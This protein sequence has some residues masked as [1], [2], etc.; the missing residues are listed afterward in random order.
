MNDQN[1]ELD[2]KIKFAGYE[3]NHDKKQ[4]YADYL[5]N[6]IE[7]IKINDNQEL[8]SFHN[9]KPRLSVSKFF[10]NCSS[11]DDKICFIDHLGYHQPAHYKNK[12][13]KPRLIKKNYNNLGV[14]LK[15]LGNQILLTD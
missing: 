1:K 12:L 3:R 8:I 4:N 10:Q 2:K 15:M 6:G 14:P 11:L 13:K 5:L 7:N 9:V